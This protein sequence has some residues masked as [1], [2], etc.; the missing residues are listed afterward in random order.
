MS[1]ACHTEGVTLINEVGSL[2]HHFNH[3]SLHL[4][5]DWFTKVIKKLKSTRHAIRVKYRIYT[6]T[7]T[8]YNLFLSLCLNSTSKKKYE[9]GSKCPQY[10]ITVKNQNAKVIKKFTAT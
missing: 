6:Q 5:Q 8:R 1:L 9:Q 7:L 10:S 4:Q 2:L 3:R